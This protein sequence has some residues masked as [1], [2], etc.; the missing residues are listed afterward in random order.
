MA[1]SHSS[2]SPRGC[3]TRA[4]AAKRAA[5]A[6]GASSPA[7]SAPAGALKGAFAKAGQ[8]ASLRH[9]RVP[10]ELRPALDA[11]Q[12]RVPP[13]PASE[14]RSA[15]ERE[16]GVSIDALFASFDDEPIG[17]ASIAQVHRA[18]LHDGSDVAVKVQYPWIAAALP[19]DLRLLRF[20]LRRALGSSG[21]GANAEFERLFDEFG[22]SLQR[23]LDF[24]IEAD[25]AREIADNLRDVRGVVVPEVFDSH[26]SPRVLTMSHHAGIRIDDREALERA[27][28][29]PERCVEIIAHAYAQQVFRDGLFHADPH[30]GNLIALPPDDESPDVRV[31][32]VDFG[33]SRRLDPELRRAL[34]HALYAVLQKDAQAFV[35]RMD[36]MGMI[37]AGARA[38]V[39]RGVG[40]MFERIADGGGALSLGAGQVLDIKDA[41]KQLLFETRGLTLPNDLLLYAKTMSYLFALTKRLAPDVDVMK[42]SLPQLLAFLASKD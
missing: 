33:L 20:A 22:D 40:A 19:A 23:E 7:P 3:A 4:A 5:P 9:D 27:G 12:D 21:N 28:V 30:P 24:R 13:L 25:T 32:F 10:P 6:R 17:A 1:G 2:S 11:L 35:D 29:S 26:T 41:A 16:F 39:E 8:F 31:L 38:D 34:R 15:I 14:I 36:E 37:A 42:I 18:T